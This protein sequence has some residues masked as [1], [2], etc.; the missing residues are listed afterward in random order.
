MGKNYSDVTVHVYFNLY[1][2]TDLP[3]EAECVSENE[4]ADYLNLKATLKTM[5]DVE[6]DNE[7]HDTYGNLIC[8][9]VISERRLPDVLCWVKDN[10]YNEEGCI[11]LD[12][13]S[14]AFD[15]SIN[16]DPGFSKPVNL[17]DYIEEH[18]LGEDKPGIKIKLRELDS[19]DSRDCVLVETADREGAMNDQSILGCSWEVPADMSIAYAIIERDADLV[20]KLEA[21]GYIID[22]SEYWDD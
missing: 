14:T 16:T 4:E 6:L 1:N 17:E 2:E 22:A 9:F 20:S 15:W 11:I 21:E 7:G 13:G 5:L 8:K 3:A 10:A 19:Y 18:E 12:N